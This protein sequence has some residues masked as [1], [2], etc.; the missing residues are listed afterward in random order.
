[1]LTQHMIKHTLEGCWQHQ[2]ENFSL[3][4]HRGKVYLRDLI[5]GYEVLTLGQCPPAELRLV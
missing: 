3:P 4:V 1:M 5:I 2:T